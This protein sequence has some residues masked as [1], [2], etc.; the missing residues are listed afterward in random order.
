MKRTL[1]L[2][3]LL[4]FTTAL[5]AAPRIIPKAPSVAAS[6]H[7]LMDF[8]SGRIITE[9]NSH[10]PLAPASLTKIMTSY[11]IFSE[12]K[13]GHITLDDEATISEKA[14]RTGG[15]KMFIEVG[16]KIS[17]N[18][19]MKGMVISS[20]NDAS[21]ALAEHIGGAEE[22]FAELMNQYSEI[23]GMKESH[24]KNAT[25]MPAEDHYTSAS[26]MAILTQAL[27]R[28][29]PEY[30]PLYAEKEF[31]FGKELKSGKPIK[32]KNRNKLLWRDE[33]VDGLKTGYTE[34]AGYC[35]VASA[36]REGMRL[37]SVVLG[38]KSTEARAQETQKLLNFGFRFYQTQTIATPSEPLATPTV[39]KGTQTVL[40]VGVEQP[41]SITLGRNQFKELNSEIALDEPLLQAP[42]EQGDVV[43]HVLFSVEGKTVAEAP[44]VALEAIEPAGLW[45]NLVDSVKLW[46]Q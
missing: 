19:L 33:S 36:Q 15:S 18:N 26:D 32:Q 23:L 10:E 12:L 8:D 22:T 24:F 37:I 29:F 28:D 35:L 38:T 43:G 14:W 11:A 30:Y 44:L 13:Q 41:L 46:F 39:W 4:L 20:G 45:K 25:G 6:A 40:P 27:I 5:S 31:I 7:I 16:K 42:I 2:L 1:P 21:V 9:G 34:A 3:L 17:V